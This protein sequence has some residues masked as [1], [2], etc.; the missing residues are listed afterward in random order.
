M[1]RPSLFIFKDLFPSKVSCLLR[2]RTFLVQ[3][4]LIAMLS[5]STHSFWGFFGSKT[6]WECSRET[7]QELA[8]GSVCAS[9]CQYPLFLL[10]QS[11]GLVLPV[12][13]L[14]A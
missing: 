7:P 5:L 1:I 14:S 6:R 12:R 9:R 4:L 10:D 13:D 3:L 11:Q 8:L 2:C